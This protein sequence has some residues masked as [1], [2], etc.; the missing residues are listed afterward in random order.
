M[1]RGRSP[2]QGRAARGGRSRPP[3]RYAW[4]PPPPAQVSHGDWLALT[5]LARRYG[6]GVPIQAMRYLRPDT[7]ELLRKGPIRKEAEFAER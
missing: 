1:R 3:P 7:I 2:A 5:Y 6:E 4:R